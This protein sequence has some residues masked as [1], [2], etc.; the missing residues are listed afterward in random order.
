MRAEKLDRSLTL[1]PTTAIVVGSVVGSGIFVSSAQ[2]TRDLQNAQIL[3]AVWIFTG[4]MTLFGALTQCELI[5]QMPTTGGLYKYLSNIYGE[6]IG[7][8]YGW[9]NFTIA[10][11]GAIAALAFIFAN[12][13]SEF[14]PLPHLGAELEAWPLTIPYVGSIFPLADLGKKMVGIILILFLTA[15]NIRGVKFGAKLQSLSTSAKVLAILGI[16]LSAFFLFHGESHLF[17]QSSQPIAGFALIAAIT[18]SMSSAF[19]AYDGW[20]NVAYIA[21]EVRHPEKTVPRAIVLGTLGFIFLYILINLAY[22]HV[23]PLSQI[24]AAP[25][26]RVAAAVMSVAVGPQGA[27]L[28]AL[29]II[30]STFDTTNSSILTNA[31]VYFAMAED[32]VFTSKAGEIHSRYQ[33][34]Y[35]ALSYQG[36]W[37]GFLLLTGS[38]DL[39]TSMYVFVNWALYIL[40][41]VGVFI[42]R[43]QKPDA[44]RPFKTPGYPLVP[45]IFVLF[46]CLFVMLTLY[47]DIHEYNLGHQPIIKSLMGTLLVVSGLPFYIYWKK[48]QHN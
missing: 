47:N 36:L 9:A 39:I 35:K 40:L 44:Q 48:Q 32:R 10:G 37:A 31:R 12:Y 5:G 4:L 23:L 43:W 3:I 28:V 29:L 7:F 8:M 21:G 27:I 46:S 24:A 19:W 34:P 30:L 25:N 18:A 33:T 20:G 16:V 41:G 1:F 13:F 14:I 6:K 38:F 45:L 2:M 17:E 22:L 11:S 42:L 26:D 15:L